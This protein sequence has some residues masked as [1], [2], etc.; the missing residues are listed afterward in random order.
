MVARPGGESVTAGSPE[1]TV[2]IP[3]HNRASML[4]LTLH[5]VLR[6]EAV[7]LEVIVIDD[8]SNDATG[9]TVAVVG[10]GRVRLVRHELPRGVSAARNHGIA[11]ARGKWVAFLDDDDLWAPDKLAAQLGA[12]RQ[13]GRRWAYVGEVNV[14]LDLRILGGAPPPFP[15]EVVAGSPRANLVPGGCSGVMV[16]T[17]ML[18][19]KPF[20]GTYYH[21]ADWDLWIRLAQRG[22]P[23]C[24]RRP[25]VAYRIHAANASLD[26]PGMIAELDMIEERYG[27]PVDRA[28]FY[29]HVG[30]VSQRAGRRRQALRYYAQAAA[31]DPRYRWHGFAADLADIT[32]GFLWQARGRVARAAG[33][34]WG[35]PP[36]APRRPDPHR[37]WKEQ[38]RPWLQELAEAGALL[39]RP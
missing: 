26:T 35:G 39:H 7:D 16:H 32:Q 8:G 6:Q 25:L 3:T 21:F 22:T 4:G 37:A 17:S 24:V 19:G 11:L 5:S 1:V 38:A 14:T 9:Q 23:A 31:R 20:D 36:P 30:R 34:P 12:A 33:R 18:V 28:R 29:R 13:Q 2:V 15:E 10:D 27:G